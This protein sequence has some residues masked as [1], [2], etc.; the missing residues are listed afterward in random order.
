MGFGFPR[1]FPLGLGGML[2]PKEK[3][4]MIDH[5]LTPECGGVKPQDYK[6]VQD[7]VSWVVD[8][9][10]GDELALLYKTLYGLG[11][12]HDYCASAIQ[13]LKDKYKP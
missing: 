10:S 2:V 5:V 13:R 11:H 7:R 12:R 1:S 8:N 6:E 3:P 4:A 9:F